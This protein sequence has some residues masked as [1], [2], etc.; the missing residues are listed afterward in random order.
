V[1][2]II[3]T[4]TITARGSRH[5]LTHEAGSRSAGQETTGSFVFTFARTRHLSIP[6]CRSSL[7]TVTPYF[8]KIDF[9]IILPHQTRS[10]EMTPP[11]TAPEHPAYRFRVSRI[12]ATSPTFLLSL[13]AFP[14]LFDPTVTLARC[15]QSVLHSHA[16]CVL[17]ASVLCATWRNTALWF[18]CDGKFYQ[19]K[20][21]F[22]GAISASA[23]MYSR[24]ALFC[25]STQ[26]RAV[27]LYRRFGT[28]IGPILNGQEVLF[29][30]L[31]LLDPLRCDR[32]VVPKRRYRIN[33]LRCVISQGSAGLISSLVL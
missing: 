7:H 33:A 32:W 6:Y 4:I 28:P 29:L 11:F 12:R 15:L 25:D 13:D 16:S 22:T 10:S 9:N 17:A 1:S 23:A 30:L 31:K 2:V 14:S 24:S 18:G 27:T 21:L 3:I 8:F 20:P 5:L 26:R 19:L